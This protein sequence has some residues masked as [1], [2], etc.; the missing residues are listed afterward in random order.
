MSSKDVAQLVPLFNSADYH[1]WK[2]RMGDFLGSQRMLGFING[3]WPRP[4]AANPAN[5]TNAKQVLMSQ[6]DEDD[7]VVRSYIALRLSPNLHTHLGTTAQDTWESLENT[8]RLSH[9]TMDF[10]LLQEVMRAKLRVDQNPQVEIQHIW[11]LLERI[12]IVGMNL[13]N[14]LQAMLLLSAI[15]KEWD[16]IAFMYC[17]DMTRQRATFDSVHTAIM[18]EYERIARPSQFAHTANRLS[19]VRHKGK[20]PQFKEQKRYSAPKP[21]ADDAPSGS[22]NKK[23]KRRGS[24]KEKAR[25]ANLIVSSAF[26]PTSVLNHMQKSH[27]HALTSQIEEVPV[28]PTLAPGY[29]MVGGPSHAPI[30]SAAPIQVA[31]FKPTGISYAKVTLL[32]MQSTSGLSSKPAPFRMDEEHELLKKAGIQPTAEPLKTAYKALKVDDNLEA[33]KEVLKKHKKFCNFASAT[34]IVQNAVASSSSSAPP[35]VPVHFKDRLKTPTPQD[36]KDTEERE[37]H[38]RQRK[39]ANTMAKKQ[40]MKAKESAHLP[41]SQLPH[42]RMLGNVQVFPEVSTNPIA[43]NGEPLLHSGNQAVFPN[44]PSIINPKHPHAKYFRALIE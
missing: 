37:K 16:R 8:F 44:S 7:T 4:Q 26:V 34:P 21:S 5:P 38:R 12:H 35:P 19:A 40:A 25:R 33:M 6:W 24:Q 9:F 22:S 30:R 31:T 13:N 11:T 39:R 28:K 17:K 36:Y 42:G 27:H 23:Q 3:N 32:P 2:E 1:A 29:T 14:Y 41:A 10:C 43:E 20:S 18:A 15:P